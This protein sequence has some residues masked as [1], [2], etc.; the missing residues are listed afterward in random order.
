MPF[1]S[2]ITQSETFGAKLRR[3]ANT[4]ET[5]NPVTNPNLIAASAW[6]AGVAV[7]NG[8]VRTS[9]GNTWCVQASGTTGGTAPTYS[10]TSPTSSDGTVTWSL[11][12]TVPTATG[13]EVP[14]FT[15]LIGGSGVGYDA[16]LTNVMTPATFG[17]SAFP[18]GTLYG[19]YATYP[20]AGIVR[21]KTFNTNATAVA[22]ANATFSVMTD[23]PIIAFQLEQTKPYRFMVDGV[24][25]SVAPQIGPSGASNP[26]MQLNFSG[27]R[28][29]RQISIRSSFTDLNVNSMR[30]GAND[31]V[32][33]VAVANNVRAVWIGDSIWSGAGAGPNL[34]GNHPPLSA[35]D[36]LG[37]N[38]CWNMSIGGTGWINKGTSSAFYNFGER[39]TEALTR[40]PDVW[41]FP[42]STNDVASTPATV[43]AAITS[44]FSAIRAAGNNA[45]IILMGIW[46]TNDSARSAGY[47]NSDF[48]SAA[49]SAVAAFKDPKMFF[50]PIATQSPLPWVTGTWNNSSDT[51]S[52]NQQIYIY[53]GDN[54]HPQEIGSSYLGARM[55]TAIKNLV[56]PSLT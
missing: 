2:A 35:S 55:A 9:N 7:T 38:D 47:K 17:G 14:T 6:S 26:W 5:K 25:L 37:W 41:V 42:L 1:L 51:S 36:Q 12:P 31:M 53:S 8:A 45:P 10:A 3:L 40:N 44:G 49:S 15:S 34:V 11:I 27:S 56:L 13:M 19:G 32:Y 20:S 52:T 46:P 4:A 48:E 24:Y 30:V 21:A 28:K 16:T 18:Y 33:P 54:I 22:C 39:I 29:I 23:S 50:I 43:A